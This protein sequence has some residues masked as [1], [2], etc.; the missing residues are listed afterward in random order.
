VGI[1]SM[2]RF[3]NSKVEGSVQCKSSTMKSIG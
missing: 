3:S 1:C 2:T